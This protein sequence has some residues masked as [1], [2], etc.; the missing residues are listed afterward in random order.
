MRHQTLKDMVLTNL[1]NGSIEED[2][3]SEQ[4]IEHN[5]TKSMNITTSGTL[6]SKVPPKSPED[7]AML[8]EES[9]DGANIVFSRGSMN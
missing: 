5:H 8:N 4:L 3:K 6:H 1:K 9:S 2:H 7:S